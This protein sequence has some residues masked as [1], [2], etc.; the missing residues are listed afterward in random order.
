MATEKSWVACLYKLLLKYA[1]PRLV[2]EKEKKLIC[3]AKQIAFLLNLSPN[4]C[5]FIF[6]FRELSHDIAVKTA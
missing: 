3:T 4:F 6:A 2:L 5:F 1:L